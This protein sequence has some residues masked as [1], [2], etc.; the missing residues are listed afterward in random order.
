MKTW[1]ALAEE[2]E[3][4][5]RAWTMRAPSQPSLRLRLSMIHDAEDA[6]AQA[7]RFRQMHETGAVITP[8]L[9]VMLSINW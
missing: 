4:V 5:A 8:G 2:Q 3:Q 9:F 1:L 7:L 6:A